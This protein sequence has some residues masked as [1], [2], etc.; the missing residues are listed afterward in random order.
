MKRLLCLSCIML[1]LMTQA[2]NNYKS[3]A[4]K[5]QRTP[6]PKSTRSTLQ[7]K[8]S[9]AS[10]KTANELLNF[11]EDK[12]TMDLTSFE[13]LKQLKSDFQKFAEHEI[14]SFKTQYHSTKTFYTHKHVCG[15]HQIEIIAKSPYHTKRISA[16]VNLFKSTQHQYVFDDFKV[17]VISNRISYF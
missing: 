9:Q 13:A 14:E 10:I 5:R 7:P 1:T 6:E 2:S 12:P 3:Q 11:I 17:L 8:P 4:S 15:Q 16:I